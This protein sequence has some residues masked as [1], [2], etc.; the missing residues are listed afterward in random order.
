VTWVQRFFGGA[1]RRRIEAA[2]IFLTSFALAA[3]VIKDKPHVER[4]LR[5]IGPFV[6]YPLAIL[7][8]TVVASAPFSVTDALAIM[9]GAIFGPLWGS[10]VNAIGLVFAA[11]A[12]YGIALRTSHLLELDKQI[13]RLPPWV[14]RFKVGSPAFLLT[15]RIIPM[16]GGTLATQIA[17]AFR[18]PVWV[19]VWTMCAIAVPICTVL[20]IF[21]DRVSVFVHDYYMAHRPHVRQRIDE[22][23]HRHHNEEPVTPERKATP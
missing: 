2:L 20:A 15:L 6:A 7:L 1:A 18:I 12:G 16:A 17:A 22:F 5:E 23:F 19:H 21:G 4:V 3:W 9:N 10:V 14:R 13:D 11:L 8:F